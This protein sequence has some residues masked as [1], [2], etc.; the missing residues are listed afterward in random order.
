[1]PVN[2]QSSFSFLNLLN[3]NGFNKVASQ[4]FQITGK[5]KNK[6]CASLNILS[7]K[8]FK[9]LTYSSLIVCGIS[10]VCFMALRVPLQI[11]QADIINPVNYNSSSHAAMMSMRSDYLPNKNFK[12]ISKI[13]DNLRMGCCTIENFQTLLTKYHATSQ[14]QETEVHAYLLHLCKD[15]GL[16][17]S[18]EIESERFIAESFNIDQISQN[19]YVKAFLSRSLLSFCEEISNPETN[20]GKFKIDKDKYEA[21]KN[22]N[23]NVLKTWDTVVKNYQMAQ[24]TI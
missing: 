16:F 23:A 18:V 24:R 13:I 1:M 5:F 21:F 9:I 22:G 11:L 6:I 7:Q 14:N 3:V 4:T 20:T 17:E 8:K 19:D 15:M 10:F 2:S 12:M